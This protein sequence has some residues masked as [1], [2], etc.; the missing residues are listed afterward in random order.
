M[1]QQALD[2]QFDIM[3]QRD[4]SAIIGTPL[5]SGKLTGEHAVLERGTMHST[6]G[7]KVYGI[8]LFSTK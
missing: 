2:V 6:S 7:S 1:D 5:A 4:M 3:D 8:D